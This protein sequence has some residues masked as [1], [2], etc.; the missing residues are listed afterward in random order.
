M[1]G[2]D[3]NPDQGQS[4]NSPIEHTYQVSA[5]ENNNWLSELTMHNFVFVRPV[6]IAGI[7][8]PNAHSGDVTRYYAL[9]PPQLNVVLLRKSLKMFKEGKEIYYPQQA[10]DE[11][12]IGGL[13]V[14]PADTDKMNK[15][16]LL[17]KT[18]VCHI[19][20]PFRTDNFWPD[21]KGTDHISFMFK[22]VDCVGIRRYVV[23]PSGAVVTVDTG[24]MRKC[25]QL[26]AIRQPLRLSST[27]ACCRVPGDPTK[28]QM[29][30]M[31]VQVPVG[32]VKNNPCNSQYE[33]DDEL[34]ELEGVICDDAFKAC[35]NHIEALTLI[36]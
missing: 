7:L 35:S 32:I 23:G 4:D 1:Y 2:E 16:V 24:D 21:C 34:N 10:A 15:R 3:F 22:L 25:V 31:G 6:H 17:K 12:K 14:T 28:E 36:I 26:V 27:M 29:W 8:D 13:C 33:R 20:S 30:A 18:I 9:T 19:R 5:W 11:W